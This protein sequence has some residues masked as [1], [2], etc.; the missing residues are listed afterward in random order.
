MSKLLWILPA[1][2]AITVAVSGKIIY[3]AGFTPSLLLIAA[4]AIIRKKEH[5]AWIAWAGLAA[6]M[7]GD[8]F[9]ALKMSPLKSPGFLYG[10]AG[11]SVAQICWII[12]L[13]RYGR[14]SFKVATGL[15]ISLGIL[16]AVRLVGVLPTTALLFALCGYTLLSIVSFSYA[17]G[18]HRGAWIWGIGFLLF[19]DTM[20]ALGNIM[21]IPMLSKLVGPSYLL[22]LIFIT[23][24]LVNFASHPVVSHSKREYL[25]RAPL[26][27]FIGGLAAVLFFVFAIKTYPG[28]NYNLRMQM[29]SHLGRTELQR[30]TYPFCC[31]LFTIGLLLAAIAVARFFPALTCF[32]HGRRRK[33]ILLWSGV[34][35]VAGL[36]VIAFIP[37][38][39]NMFFH[40]VG[41]VTAA[42]GGGVAVIVLTASGGNNRAPRSARK[43]W[44]IWMIG[45]VAV[46]E[47]FLGL[48]KFKVLPF[49]PYVPTIQKILILSFIFWICF[50]AGL[51]FR[52]LHKKITLK[53]ATPMEN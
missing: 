32:V 40:N 49:S 7:V 18:S 14:F 42:V 36:A 29:L 4:I 53:V 24:G 21:R 34:L 10:V 44:C 51:L 37:E 6:T 23:I 47:V 1:A 3:L 41:C 17:C 12:F 5:G 8:Y 11:F 16:F 33:E 38:N 46:F 9:L 2:V 20:I 25:R 28:F 15:L 22:A 50:Y 27:A 39:I 26:I 52:R 43:L 13:H 19:S 45:L 30:I 31:Y 48:H 35:N